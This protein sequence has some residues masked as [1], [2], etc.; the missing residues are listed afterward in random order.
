M[1]ILTSRGPALLVMLLVV[2]AVLDLSHGSVMAQDASPAATLGSPR[3][4]VMELDLAAMALLPSDLDAL[5][6]SGYGVQVGSTLTVDE[7]AERVVPDI[8]Q[9]PSEVVAAL[10]AAGVRRRYELH[11]GLPRQPG[12]TPARLHTFV[13]SYVLGYTT[14]A[15][16]AACGDQSAGEDPSRDH[17]VAAHW[18]PPWLLST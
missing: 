6:I 9:D 5:A 14:A 11:I 10:D 1:S 3:P 15:G 18:S 17:A 8:G 7:Q 2:V 13:A 4:V 16:V 12:E